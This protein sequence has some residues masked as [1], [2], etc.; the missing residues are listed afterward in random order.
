[1]SSEAGEPRSP[2]LLD[3]LGRL[4]RT[5]LGLART[6]LEILATEIEEE[7]IRVTQLALL[8]AAIVFCLQ[9]AL[10]L[11]VVLVVV[12]LWDSHRVITLGL[13]GAVFLL[14]AVAGAARLRF[15]LRT[16][17][18]IFASTIAELAKDKERLG[19]GDK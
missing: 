17:P 13:L 7:R 11:L 5:A 10:V 3:S 12:L 14:A 9:V 6:R 2:G 4:A 15:L 19:G 1:M 18:K 8:V 16:R